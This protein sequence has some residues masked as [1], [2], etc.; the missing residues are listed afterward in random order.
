L[1]TL[2]LVIA[3]ALPA[4]AFAEPEVNIEPR[5]G[6]FAVRAET[7]VEVTPAVAWQVLTDYDRLAEYV[8]DMRASRVI[9]APGAPLLVEQQ[10]RAGFLMFGYAI[11]VV[12]EIEEAPPSRLAFRAIRG[13]M[14]IMRGE[15][16][17]DGSAA[18]VTRLV[19]EAVLEPSFWVPPLIGPAILRRDISSRIAGVVREMVRRQGAVTIQL[20]TQSGK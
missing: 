13:N 5:G 12:L 2:S 7:L 8:P 10:G 17:F 18:G 9:S 19:Y 11:D 16:S 20:N 1:P 15:W 14:R 3:L 6:G 4:P